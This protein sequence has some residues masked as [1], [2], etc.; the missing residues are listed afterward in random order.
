MT[1]RV[2]VVSDGPGAGRTLAR[3]LAGDD[4]SAEWSTLKW[5]LSRGS[6]TVDVV[7]LNGHG[8][9][10]D[11]AQAVVAARAQIRGPVVVLTS[12][13]H[14][15]TLIPPLAAGA[16]GVVLRTSGTDV[17]R[18]AVHAVRKGGLFIDPVLG[19]TIADLVTLVS[20]REHASDLTSTELRVLQRFPHGMTNAAMADD[21]GVSVNTVKT[22]VRHIL[23]KLECEDRMEAVKVAKQFGLLP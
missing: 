4:L 10:G 7:V 2:C 19:A 15:S 11:V 22:H 6:D 12:D 14:E 20:R 3:A 5:L 9:S 8:Y 13:A 1:C 18:R 17:L 16:R 23:A 21:L